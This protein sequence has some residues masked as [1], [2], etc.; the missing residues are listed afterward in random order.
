MSLSAVALLRVTAVILLTA[1]YYWLSHLFTAADRP[2]TAGALLAT[3]P[4]LAIALL[5]AWKSKRREAAILL[6]LLAVAGMAIGWPVLRDNFAWIY[7]FQHVGAFSLL[8]IGF[9][10]TL[11]NGNTPMISRF[12]ERVHG[13]LAPELARYTRGATL[14]WTLF[15]IAMV[16]LSLTLFFGAPISWWSA[17]ANLATPLLIALMFLAEFIVRRRLPKEFRTGLIESI[18]AATGHRTPRHGGKLPDLNPG[19]R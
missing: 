10:R 2:S 6:W 18:R 4:Y 19:A 7:L 5:M 1:L 15:F 9:G 16:S 13:E 17:F 11:A 12:A 3:T 14:A 8:A